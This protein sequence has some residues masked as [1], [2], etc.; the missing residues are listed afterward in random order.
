[1]FTWFQA[2]GVPAPDLPAGK[3]V[4]RKPP[5][6]FCRT[7]PRFPGSGIRFLF[8]GGTAEARRIVPNVR[9]GNGTRKSSNPQIP[10][11]R[12]PEIP[13]SRNPEIPKSRNPE[14]PKSRNPEIPKSRHPDIPTSRHPDIPTSRHPDIPTSRHPDIP[15]S[16]HPDIPKRFGQRAVPA[17]SAHAGI[18][19][20]GRQNTN[21]GKAQDAAFPQRALHPDFR[22]ARRPGR[23][24]HAL[25][26]TGCIFQTF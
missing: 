9:S 14:I 6:R 17:D 22:P 4:C 7:L 12:N 10:K 15:T 19:S 3:T 24:F 5:G 8:C 20:G 13:K 2:A 26:G 18:V 11:S 23:F 25:A 21:G 1:M 16:R